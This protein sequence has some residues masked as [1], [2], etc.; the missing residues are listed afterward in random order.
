M[1]IGKKIK[2]LRLKK[3]LTQEELAERTDLT[4]GH[5]SQL[6]RELNSPSIE[7]LFSLLE[8]LGT[9]PKDFFDETKKNVKVVYTK[10]EQIV[11]AD[12]DL[13]YKIR[14]LVPRSNENEMD[15]VQI[16]FEQQGQFKL[17]E[18]SSSE[19]FIYVQTGIVQIELGDSIYTASEGDAVYYDA[20]EQHRLTNVHKG[21]T[22]II[23]VATES[24][25]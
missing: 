4:K 23:L 18:P 12:H 13:N 17:F 3:G 7:T 19:T 16:E 21:K 20:S 14:W 2:S 22:T 6:E 25:L 8:V 24:Y 5:I 1:E 11:Y 9:T 15:P 10:D